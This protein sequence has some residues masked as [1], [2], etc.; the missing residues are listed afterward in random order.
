[1]S[2]LQTFKIEGLFVCVLTVSKFFA[3][4]LLQIKIFHRLKQDMINFS[5]GLDKDEK[6]FFS[7]TKYAVDGICKP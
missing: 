4:L 5:A 7:H 3:A 6:N 2:L 1:V